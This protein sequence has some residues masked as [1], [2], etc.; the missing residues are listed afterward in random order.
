MGGGK[1]EDGAGDGNERGDEC[2]REVSGGKSA[3][4]SAWIGGV[5]GGIGEA[6]E[7]H[8]GGA[9][10]D[11][12]DNDPEKLMHG[13]KT[14]GGEHGSAESEWESEDGVLPLNHL[15]GDTEV[16]ENGHEEIVT[17]TGYRLPFRPLPC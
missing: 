16:A 1:N 9:C 2:R 12:G 15:E 4:A 6:I 10:G 8:G 5:D 11:H 17:E 3:S 13:G 14:G 7:G